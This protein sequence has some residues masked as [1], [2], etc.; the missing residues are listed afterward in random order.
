MVKF[1]ISI[2]LALRNLYNNKVR[3]TLSLL[4]IV[5]GV[6][7]VILILSLGN[8]LR[9]FVVGQVE[10]FGTDIV[11]I[12]VKVPKT[13]HISSENAGSMAGGMQITTL[14]L[15]EVEDI[16]KLANLGA[17]YG[18]ILS[19]QITSREDENE[20]SFIF[21]V[22]DGMMEAD[23]GA[24]LVAGSFFTKED[25]RDLKQVAVLG[26]KA[27]EKFF[28]N[29]EAVGE[30]L[31][32]GGKKYK[33]LGVLEERGA[34][35]GFDF[36]EVVFI[37]VQTLQKKIMGIEHIQFAI[38]KVKNMDLVERTMEEMRM[39][40]RDK[41]D[42]EYVNEKDKA[43]GID[44]DFA[45][46]SIAEA[47]EILDKVFGAINILLISLASIS[48]VVGGVGIMNV[49][50]VAVTERTQEIG[51]RKSVGARNIDIL[52]QFIFEAIFLTLLGGLI[53]IIIG[54]ALS[55]LTTYVITNKYD[56]S[57]S[58]DVTSFS[59]VIAVGF[60]TIVGIIFGFYPARKASQLTPSEA[61]RKD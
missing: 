59:I 3:T 14:K 32:I 33:I 1:I 23:G 45:V 8:G 16:A 47:K 46:M 52:W 34:T 25:D 58:F 39:I 41:H 27:K 48:L 10:S 4:G 55:E 2:R 30:S 40:M 53:G 51:L 7:S 57:V 36:D 43:D 12:E 31:K 17:W 61:L 54:I 26:S 42:I 28:P 44:D 15:D 38:F 29:D 20:Q 18:G 56:Y 35:G 19:Q 21:G 13:S 11:Q 49:M 24:K 60:S 5:I 50:Y 22:T 37:P 6:A 9:N